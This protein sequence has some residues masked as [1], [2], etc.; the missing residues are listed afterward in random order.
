MLTIEE[1]KSI[2][3]IQYQYLQKEKWYNDPAFSYYKTDEE[4]KKALDSH[5]GIPN[6]RIKGVKYRVARKT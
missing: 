6:A 2:Y 4:A 3:T 5:P 1:S